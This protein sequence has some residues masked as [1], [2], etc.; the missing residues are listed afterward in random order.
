MLN[1]RV[2]NEGI[3]TLKRCKEIQNL[4]LIKIMFKMFKLYK[5]KVFVPAL[6]IVISLNLVQKCK[7]GLKMNLLS[8]KHQEI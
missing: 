1:L 3:L 4:W 5:I 8:N 7:V 2:I 6:A